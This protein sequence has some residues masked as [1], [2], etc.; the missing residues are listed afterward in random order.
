MKLQVS[1]H[2]GDPFGMLMR[3][4]IGGNDFFTFGVLHARTPVWHDTATGVGRI[5]PLTVTGDHVVMTCRA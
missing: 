2:F 3:A 4:V 1:A 5:A